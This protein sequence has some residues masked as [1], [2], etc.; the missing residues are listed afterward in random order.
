MVIVVL[1]KPGHSMNIASQGPLKLHVLL[2]ASYKQKPKLDQ[3]GVVLRLNVWNMVFFGL[4][5]RKTKQ[6]R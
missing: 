1:F 4:L 3:G 2:R 5:L 6:G